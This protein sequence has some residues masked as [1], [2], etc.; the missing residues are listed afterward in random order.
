MDVFDK[1]QNS[2]IPSVPRRREEVNMAL[3][4]RIQ[5]HFFKMKIYQKHIV[6]K[7]FPKKTQNL[8]VRRNY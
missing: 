1:F 4:S 2:R 6:N 3:K 5:F 7:H 8:K